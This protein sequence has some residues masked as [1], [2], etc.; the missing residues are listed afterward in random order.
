MICSY[1]MIFCNPSLSL[2]TI[3]ITTALIDTNARARTDSLLT[4]CLECFH[5]LFAALLSLFHIR[6]S[7]L[8][9]LC[10]YIE[11]SLLYQYFLSFLTF[12]DFL[13]ISTSACTC[14][15]RP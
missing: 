8:W 7:R 4:A 5:P 6:C 12:E 9:H 11:P 15:D 13:R 1:D 14:Y 10:M 3:T 2:N